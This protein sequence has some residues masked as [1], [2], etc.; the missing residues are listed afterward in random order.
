MLPPTIH[1]ENPNPKLGLES[2]N[3]YLN[4]GTR[5]WIQGD[6]TPRRAGVNAFG[7]GG[8]NAHGCWKKRSHRPQPVS[9]SHMNLFG[10]A[11]WSL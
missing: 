9:Q 3:F 7:F 1:C 6:E 5:P 11:R 4:S 2:S 10:T 8:V